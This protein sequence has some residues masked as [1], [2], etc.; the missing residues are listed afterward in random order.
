MY[1]DLPPTVF[2]PGGHLYSVQAVLRQ[3]HNPDD[4]TSNLVVA[5]QFHQGVVVVSTLV[6]SPYF[7]NEVVAAKNQTNTTTTMLKNQ[8]NTTETSLLWNNTNDNDIHLHYPSPFVQLHH[9]LWGVTAGPAVP[10]QTAR[11]LLA[12]TLNDIPRPARVVARQLADLAQT[13]TQ[14]AS[15]SS[16]LRSTMSL[17]FDAGFEQQQQSLWRIDPNGQFWQCRAAC[18][19]RGATV[20]M[21]YDL[22][23]RLVKAA[24]NHST[25]TTNLS[26]TNATSEKEPPQL[27]TTSDDDMRLL[28]EEASFTREQALRAAV[29]TI[30]AS[31]PDAQL[32]ALVVTTKGAELVPH[33]QLV[34]LL[35]DKTN[36]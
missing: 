9:R 6:Q 5:I 11:R 25:G 33:S 28:W 4:P 15:S 35:D 32:R 36:A 10:S 16:T 20:R 26:K 24:S 23:E 2:A 22:Q 1:K 21:E 3:V 27:N 17:V 18:I 7:Y 30:R 8:T 19:G 34:A 29:E 31:S 14:S 13:A 12:A